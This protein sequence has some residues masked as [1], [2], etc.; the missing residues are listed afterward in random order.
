MLTSVVLTV[1]GQARTIETDPQRPLLHVLR[2]D[3]GMTGTK[4]SC[5]EG[6]CGACTVLVDGRCV[7]SCVTPVSTVAGKQ[8]VTIEGL[9]VGDALHRVQE[10]FV[11][12]GAMQCGYCTGGMILTAVA[13]LEE[14]ARPSDREIVEWLDANICGCNGYPKIVS[15]IRKASQKTK[16]E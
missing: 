6:Q 4:Y 16:G 13:L 3:L 9:A 15:S 10:A 8:I 5:G 12:E 14:N 2:E 1:N 11:E 7:R